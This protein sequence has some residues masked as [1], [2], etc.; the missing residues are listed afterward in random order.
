M[1][2]T[3]EFNRMNLRFLKEMADVDTYPFSSIFE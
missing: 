1:Q 3:T 2:K